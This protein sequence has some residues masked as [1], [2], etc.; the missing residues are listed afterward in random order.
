ML[1]DNIV[2]NLTKRLNKFLFFREIFFDE[3][4]DIVMAKEGGILRRD[5][6]I[7]LKHVDEICDRLPYSEKFQKSDEE[8]R[9]DIDSMEYLTVIYTHNYEKMR[10]T[11][12]EARFLG[13]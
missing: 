1:S 10:Y 11:E 6:K 12:F 3:R 5:V 8:L 7:S 4:G 13:D 2:D 9:P